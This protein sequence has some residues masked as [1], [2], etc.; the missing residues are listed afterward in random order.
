MRR[1]YLRLALAPSSVSKLPSNSRGSSSSA[2][3]SHP[4]EYAYAATR[5]PCD[6]NA[7]VITTIWRV[8]VV[9]MILSGS[10]I[11]AV[12]D[13]SGL[14]LS[15]FDDRH[16]HFA[17]FFG[18]TLLAVSAYLRA[19]LTHVLLVLALLAGITELLQFLPGVNREPDWS[20]FAFDILGI[21]CALIAVA[22]LRWLFLQAPA[23][24]VMPQAG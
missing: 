8:L 1:E 6:L 13:L 3:P 20:D 18:A 23:A 9:T 22:V 2:I 5:D 10:A 15:G 21:D 16:L 7:R 19:P 14:P 11:V 17:A 24:P 4:P 12:A